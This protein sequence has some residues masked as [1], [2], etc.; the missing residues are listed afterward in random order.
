[1]ADAVLPATPVLSPLQIAWLQETGLDK[2][3]LLRFKAPLD[4]KAGPA[5]LH[6]AA[7]AVSPTSG[8]QRPPTPLVAPCQE[9]HRA[10]HQASNLLA[11]GLVGT[12]V[13]LE[14]QRIASGAHAQSRAEIPLDWVALQASVESCRECDLSSGRSQA[15]FGMGT[16]QAA[17]WMVI[18]E[19]PGDQDDRAG[20]PF[21]GAAGHLLRAMLG[22]VGVLSDAQV[23]FTNLVKCRPLGNRPPKAQEI[24]ACL[25][26]LQRQFAVLQPQRILVLGRLA[27]QALLG[28]DADLESLRGHVHSFRSET[29][30]Q[31]PLVVT[32]HPV[33]LLSRPQHKAGAWRDLNLALAAADH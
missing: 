16:A 26:Y 2:S 11:G 4:A 30:Q 27:A 28:T 1:M 8:G 23:F 12:G 15:V 31:I 13:L 33:S 25:P 9:P 10:P 7:P 24:A 20:M 17:R 29:G 19:A 32:Y 22:S 3:L 6:V 14:G 21:Q 5:R 18:G